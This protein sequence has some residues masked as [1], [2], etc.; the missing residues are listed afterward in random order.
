MAAAR[1]P[2]PI[3]YQG[4]KRQLARRIL[5]VLSSSRFGT[6]YEPFAGSAALTIAACAA[7]TAERFVIGDTLEPLTELW[8]QIL[9]APDALADEYERIWSAQLA[10]PAAHYLKTRAAFNQ[11]GRAAELLY[12]LARC[13]KNAPRFNSDG[14]FNQSAD[15]RRLGMR[16]S[17]MRQEVAGA[18][19][20]L[21]GRTEVRSLDFADAVAEATTRDLV[22]MDPPWEG[23][24]KGSN[25]RYR[26]W[27]ARERLI[28]VLE[29]L[30][31]RGVSYILSYD[32]RHGAKSYGD[33]LPE[34]IG[35]VRLE[36]V[37]G[38]SSQAT[39]NGRAVTTI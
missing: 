35:A 34:S 20:L 6:F 23:T 17:K 21:G 29:D 36:L 38:R 33:W 2:H 25:K 15:H 7:D 19:A 13:V 1:L 16:P 4:S 14:E 9:S 12:L 39:L 18:A 30:D 37:A 26:D 8:T 31:A 28:E 24:S 32:G 27:L 11:A 10:D 22:Y 5:S 3:P